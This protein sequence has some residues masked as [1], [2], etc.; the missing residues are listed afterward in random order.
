MPFNTITFAVFFVGVLVLYWGARPNARNVV[1]VVSSYVFYGWWDWRFLSLLAI[2]TVVDYSLGLG[3]AASDDDRRRKRLMLTSVA[4]NLGIL[5]VFKYLNFFADSLTEMFDGLGW[6]ADPFTLTVILP[7]GISFYTFQTMSYSLDVYR[8]RIE[9]T[10]DVVAFATYVAYF[11]QLVAGPIERAQNLLPAILDTDRRFPVD[12]ER[13]DAIRL[14]L[15]GL[16]KKVVL[17]DGVAEIANRAFAESD[18]SSAVAL[19]TGVVAFAIQIYGDFS[20]YTDIARGV[21]KLLGIDLVVNF[22]E[23]YLSRNITEFWRRWHISLS[24][25]L[26]DYLYISLGGN[27]KGTLTTYRNLM[28]TML[29]GGLWHGASWNFVIWGGLHGLYLVIHKLTRGGK[30]ATHE[31]CLRDLPAIIVTNVA[32]LFA[33]I[34]FRANGL[35]EAWDVISGIATLRGGS[36]RPADVATV[37]LFTAIMIG[38][39]LWQR[40]HMD[41]LSRGTTVS[42]SPVLQ[43]AGAGFLVAAV[44]L[45]SGGT[46]VPF[47]YFQF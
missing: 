39:D 9:P 11:P 12:A 46:P 25:W 28:L 20:G 18:T 35:G 41:R 37:A 47:I 43:G 42:V 44:V 5:G 30:E 23:P 13:R 14:I 22:T 2:S 15:V 21:S 27:R 17:A 3:M 33:W 34:F 10:R 26:R 6:Q 4:V 24:N 38:G 32:V 29:L 8:R 1:L 45:F 16:A 31:P 7:V 19:T 40:S 36:I